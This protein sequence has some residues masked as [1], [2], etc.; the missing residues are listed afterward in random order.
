MGFV[1]FKP[2]IK[3][4]AIILKN[5]L[6]IIF[7]EVLKS[8]ILIYMVHIFVIGAVDSSRMEIPAYFTYF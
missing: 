7:R 3:L 4:A 5:N 1:S 2:M 8:C 6:E